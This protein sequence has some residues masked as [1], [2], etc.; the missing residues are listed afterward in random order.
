M[1]GGAPLLDLAYEE[2]SRADVDMNVVKTADGRFIELQGT[3]EA[4][5]FDRQELDSLLLLADKG[6]KDLID[7][8]REIVGSILKY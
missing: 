5:P 4:Q 6:I 8:Q 1:V 2:D 7:K 3:A